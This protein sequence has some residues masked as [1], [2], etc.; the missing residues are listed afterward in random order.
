MRNRILAAIAA[1]CAASLW[2][3]GPAA[4]AKRIALVV[5]ND[6]YVN[7]TK[8]GKA[9]NDS[10]AVGQALEE[11]GF[12]VISAENTTRREMNRRMS[13]LDSSI[14]PGD[15][16][17]FFFA[18]HGVAIGA[19]N[20][21]LPTDIPKPR[22]GEE[23]LV[24]DEAHSVDSIIE[25][26]RSRG[27]A[28][29]MIVLDA[30]RDNPFAASGTRN[31]GSQRGLARVEA[32]D[33][34]FVLYSAGIG[35]TALDALGPDD[36]DQNSVFTRKLVPLLRTTGMTHVALA[37]TVQQQVD[38]LASTVHHPQQPAYY[39][40]I[41]GE[42]VLKPQQEIVTSQ[43]SPT[44]MSEAAAAWVTVNN[45]KSIAVLEAYIER[46]KGTVFADLAQAR[47]DEVK[48]AQVATLVDRT[49]AVEAKSEK[50]SDPAATSASE[51][52]SVAPEIATV[53]E[54]GAI[55]G[56]ETTEIAAIESAPTA[57]EATEAAQEIDPTLLA[58]QLQTELARVGCYQGKVDG[59][60][61]RRSASA[62]DS[63]NAA[64][65]LELD[66]SQPTGEALEKVL[67]SQEAICEARTCSEGLE[68]DGDGN[69]VKPAG[70]VKK[71]VI[72]AKPKS[73][74]KV[75][76]SKPKSEPKVTKAR[77]K[78]E[79]KAV[80][81]ATTTRKT[82]TVT[83]EQPKRKSMMTKSGKFDCAIY[84]TNTALQDLH[85]RQG[86]CE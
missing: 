81:K 79:P 48:R 52:A 23:G 77:P 22:E 18:G 32:P 56:S 8:L 71:K 74:P 6:D 60:W 45:S 34:V 11:I 40:Q 19:E 15:S 5:G 24:R 14:A 51:P 78:S 55:A 41:I 16:V 62:L 86:H 10:R 68:L 85:R 13:E 1:F 31:L 82:K 69:C 30:C 64:T 46:F 54:S 3:A 84:G 44:P 47:L 50:A 27:A 75:T 65:G 12:S 42:I 2:L 38:H 43:A 73:E 26:I 72:R 33:G 25:R 4:A 21:L 57:E 63:F 61:G 76:R 49:I 17:F 39:D 28:V 67:A 9:V 37:K 7:L 35:Q 80:K 83:T 53:E 59:D 70:S 20:Y 58:Q 29:S 66:V 36:R